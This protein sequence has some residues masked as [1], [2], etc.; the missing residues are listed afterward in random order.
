MT[1][2]RGVFTKLEYLILN[3]SITNI[4]ERVPPIESQ[5][6][7]LVSSSDRVSIHNAAITRLL[8]ASG[9]S[10]SIRLFHRQK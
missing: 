5:H 9:R 3:H 2:W 10:G 6:P 1:L 7:A 8:T 4:A